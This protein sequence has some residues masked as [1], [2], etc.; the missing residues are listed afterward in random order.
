[1]KRLLCCLFILCIVLCGCTEGG[2]GASSS[3]VVS[4]SFDEWVKEEYGDPNQ[5]KMFSIDDY[6]YTLAEFND[7]LDGLNEAYSSDGTTPDSFKV[8]AGYRSKPFDPVGTHA[9]AKKLFWQVCEEQ[10]FAAEQMKAAE[11]AVIVSY[12]NKN[13]I[14][15]VDYIFNGFDGSFTFIVGADGKFYYFAEYNDGDDDNCRL[16]VNGKDISDDNYVYMSHL[17][18]HTGVPMVSILEELG[19]K[20][21]WQS[22]TTADIYINDEKY[23]LDTSENTLQKPGSDWN[24]INILPGTK[25]GYEYTMVDGEYTVDGS[26]LAWFLKS[27]GINMD[28]DYEESVITVTS[29]K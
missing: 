13:E 26:Y 11:H 28:I 9:D 27:I 29:Q 5:I 17:Y 1:M 25:N 20:V 8:L 16:F 10:G 15:R 14:W 2:P 24:Y 19:A 4:L 6:K 18:K 7:V 12:D 23:I 22:D 3:S 21:R